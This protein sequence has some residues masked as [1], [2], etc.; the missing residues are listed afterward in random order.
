MSDYKVTLYKSSE[1]EKWN[2]FV[3]NSAEKTFL[4]QR[5]FMEYHSDRFQDFSLMI[6]KK[7]SLIA[8][9]PAN[10][11]EDAIYS[12]QGLT[13]GGFILDNDLSKSELNPICQ[14]LTQFLKAQEIR[15]VELKLLPGCYQ[16]E[17]SKMLLD[18]LENANTQ[19][20][21]TDMV[22][23][24]DY[25]A[26]LQ[27]HKT[28]LKH[29]R[30]N[31]IKGFEI[32]EESSL[33]AFW[34]SVLIPRL[35]EKHKVKPVHSLD[36]IQKLKSK[37][38]NNIRQFNIYLGSEILAGI[39]IFDK[40]EVIKSQYGA[41]TEHGEKERALEFLFMHLIYKFKEEGRTFFS[42]GTVRDPDR[43]LGYNEGLLKQKEELGCT[44]F[45]QHFYKLNI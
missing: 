20:F 40:G 1:K 24:I 7:N 16:K 31:K 12:H 23:A 36:E 11:F 42:M 3:E 32:K 4:F 21:R 22:L 30:K 27:I 44:V 18:Y 28:K 17:A 6:Y 5:D 26:P 2:R 45:K 39:T 13:Y 35:K 43:P 14:S 33:D 34:N 37:F 25:S 41:T 15:S 10:C 8:L 29:Y 38:P 9:L 19:N